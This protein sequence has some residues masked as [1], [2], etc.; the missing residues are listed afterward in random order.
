MNFNKDIKS[1]GK[2]KKEVKDNQLKTLDLQ[3]FFEIKNIQIA[4]PR[5]Y[6]EIVLEKDKQHNN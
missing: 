5:S 2:Y 3:K 6:P 4:K 1:A